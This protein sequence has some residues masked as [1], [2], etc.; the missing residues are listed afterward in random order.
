MNYGQNQNWV[1][2]KLLDVEDLFMGHISIHSF[3]EEFVLKIKEI[4]LECLSQDEE[5]LTQI[6]EYCKLPPSIEISKIELEQVLDEMIKK[7][8][9]YVNNKWKTENDKFP[10][11]LTEKGKRVWLKDLSD[12]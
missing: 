6:M 1:F 8:I 11:S 4:V 7:G 10:Y 12:I 5:A 2:I 9:I 3:K